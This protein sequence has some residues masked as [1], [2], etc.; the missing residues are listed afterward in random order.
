MAHCEEW[1]LSME[2]GTTR[3]TAPLIGLE[4][5]R[6]CNRATYYYDMPINRIPNL[7]LLPGTKELSL[8]QTYCRYGRWGLYSRAG[9]FLNRSTSRKLPIWW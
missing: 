7:Y 2:Y 3:D 5:S 4:Q 8:S 9:F 1:Y 6:G